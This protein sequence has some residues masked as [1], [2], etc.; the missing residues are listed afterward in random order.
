[1]RYLSIIIVIICIVHQEVKAQEVETS[2]SLNRI[3]FHYEDLENFKEVLKI[4]CQKGDT[5][6]AINEYFENGSEG[7]KAW[8]KRYSVNPKTIRAALQYFPSYYNYLSNLDTVLISYEGKISKGLNGLKKLYPSEFIHIPPVYYFILFAG[9]GSVEMTANMISIDY[10][11]LHDNLDRSEFDRIGGLFPE[12]KLSLINVA[13]IPQVAIHETAHLLQ[14]YMQG[15]HDYS[16][17]YTDKDKQTIL[18]YAIR[19]G[20]ADFL[21]YHGAGLVD[22]TKWVYGEKHEKELWK[23]M[24]PIL[25]DHI[26]DHPGWFSGKFTEHPD[27]P[28]QIGYYVGSKIVQYFFETSTD[29]EEAIKHILNSHKKDDF[30]IFIDL[31]RKKWS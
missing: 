13:Q 2:T 15:E 12:G 29:K 18:A 17:I 7:M 22:S 24:E 9:G 16:S 8:I 27:W 1:M 6:Q 10:F 19:E 23:A 20:G 4:I 25:N 21:T 31:Y 30:Q 11:G 28:Y 5:L 14:S 3:D 26:D